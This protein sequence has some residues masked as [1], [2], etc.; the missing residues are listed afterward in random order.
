[1]FGPDAVSS[2]TINEFKQMV[3]GVRFIENCLNNPVDKNDLRL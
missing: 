2:L 3:D 1:M